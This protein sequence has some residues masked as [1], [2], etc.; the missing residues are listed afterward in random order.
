MKTIDI[1]TK[2]FSKNLIY[3]ESDTINITNYVENNNKNK[4]NFNFWELIDT[5]D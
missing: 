3:L 2:K 4:K 1:K 5:N